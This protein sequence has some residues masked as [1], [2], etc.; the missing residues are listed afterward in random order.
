[1]NKL[2]LLSTLFLFLATGCKKDPCD[3]VSCGLGYCISGNCNCNTTDYEGA[4]CEIKKI[5]KFTGTYNS[6]EDNCNYAHTVT[7][8]EVAITTV[9][10][11]NLF[12]YNTYVNATLLY[13]NLTIPSQVVSV[14]DGNYVVSGSATLYGNTLTVQYSLAFFHSTNSA[15]NFT[16]ACTT[17]CYK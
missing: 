4:H 17:Y 14:S 2:L 16:D 11:Y 7:V 15:Y 3:G 1:M 8:A 5:T 9:R 10:I 13:D 6:P 12:E